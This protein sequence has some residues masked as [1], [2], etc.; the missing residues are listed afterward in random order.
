MPN[1]TNMTLAELRAASKPDI[2]KGVGR[3]IA[4]HFTKRQI[5]AWLVL[6]NTEG[7]HIPDKVIVTKGPHGNVRRVERYRDPATGT[8]LGGRV[9]TKSYYDTGEI[10]DIIISD[11][12][13]NSVETRRVR[14]RHFRDGR[15]PVMR[16]ARP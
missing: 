13:E 2:L 5:I 10:H 6:D 16:D 12:D 4:D 8:V 1:W 3:Y 14:I 15:Q 11:R 7:K 9:T